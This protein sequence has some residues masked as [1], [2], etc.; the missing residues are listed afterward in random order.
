MKS[1]R[2]IF[3]TGKGGVGKTSVACAT[4]INLAQS[5][6][7]V[8]LVSTDPASNLDDVLEI[9]VQQYPTEIPGIPALL[10]MNLDPEEAARDYREKVVGDY[11]G[12]LPDDVI[13]SMEEQLSGACTVEIATFDLFTRLLSDP[14]VVNS[15]DHFVFDTAPTGHTLR[16]LALPKAWSGFMTENVRGTSCIGPLAGMFEQKQRYESTVAALADPGLVTLTLVTKPEGPALNEAWRASRELGE[17]GL[18][19]QRL[20]IN[21]VLNHSGKDQVAN[22]FKQQ[23]SESLERMPTELSELPCQVVPLLHVPPVGIAGLKLLAERMRHPDKQVVVW[24]FSTEDF[25]PPLTIPSGLS[26]V[27]DDLNRRDNGLVLV[28]GK[29]GVGKTTIAAAI[30][31]ALY[32]RGKKV[33]LSTTDPAAHLD[34]ALAG[35]GKDLA[36]SRIDPAVEVAAYRN[37]VMSTVGKGLDEDG[38]ALLAEELASPCTEEIAVFR[39]FAR[40]VDKAEESFVVLDTAPTGHTLLLLDATQSYHRQVENT[41]G[42]VPEEVRRLLPRLRDP[43]FTYILLVTLAQA[44]PVLEAQRLQEDLRRAGIEPAWWLINQT[45]TGVPTSNLVLKSLSR[46]EKPWIDKVVQTLAKKAVRIPWLTKTPKGREGLTQ[47]LNKGSD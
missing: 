1:T 13:A 25:S 30:A 21:G 18:I 31:L 5:G 28:M 24:D 47:L 36:V 32:A 11:R 44:T 42:D 8:L 35:A 10:A 16:L 3:F 6:K 4:A 7:N 38:R 9:K 45:W 2:Y 22:A 41:T 27:V 34:L 15:Y 14:A 20:I 12:I 23:Q 43:E 19:N 26:S 29:G 46:A 39:A 17:L 37:E 33:R 40:T